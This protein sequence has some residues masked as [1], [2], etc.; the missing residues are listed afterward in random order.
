MVFASVPKENY[1]IDRGA[2]EIRRFRSSEKAERWFCSRCGTPLLF[3][4]LEGATH[5]FSV[6]TL[7]NPEVV[8]PGFHIF[9]DSRIA[10]ADAADDLP[11]FAR[12]R[13]G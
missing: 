5:E 7:D 4:E 8:Q 6:A 1:V 2:D 12:S 9:Y 13:H 3:R 10:W 11:Q